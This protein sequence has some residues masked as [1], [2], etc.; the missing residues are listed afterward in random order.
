MWLGLT[1]I[2][3]VGFATVLPGVFQARA[4]SPEV[5][6]C[7]DGITLLRNELLTRGSP[8]V[9]GSEPYDQELRRFL[10]EW[11]ARKEGLR[12]L[13]QSTAERR[14]H[15]ALERLRY[16]LETRMRRARREIAPILE[17]IDRELGSL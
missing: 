8:A 9:V 3:L 10:A 13:C 2:V 12:E 15:S 16:R 17:E 6:S 1:Y 7:S 14:A 5:E 11:D 4:V